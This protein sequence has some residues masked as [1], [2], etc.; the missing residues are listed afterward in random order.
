MVSIEDDKEFHELL[1]K[2][3]EINKEGRKKLGASPKYFWDCGKMYVRS[4][5]GQWTRMPPLPKKGMPKP[6]DPCPCG[7]GKKYKKCCY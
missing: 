4:E 6:N 7:S 3:M 5:L 1:I 2:F